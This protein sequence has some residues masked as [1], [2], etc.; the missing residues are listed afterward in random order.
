MASLGDKRSPDLRIPE[1]E[2][3]KYEYLLVPGPPRL[4]IREFRIPGPSEI[5]S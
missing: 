3:A 2:T 4:K 1:S 5:E